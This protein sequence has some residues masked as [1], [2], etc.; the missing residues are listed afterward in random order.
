MNTVKKYESH[1][2]EEFWNEY[3]R[4]RQAAENNTMSNEKMAAAS[5]RPAD[6]VN[7]DSAAPASGQMDPIGLQGKVHS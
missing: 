3:K 5:S 1:P 6:M 4:K 2:I 7:P